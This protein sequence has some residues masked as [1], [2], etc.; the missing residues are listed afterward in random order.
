MGGTRGVFGREGE[1]ADPVF[2][3]GERGLVCERGGGGGCDVHGD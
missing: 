3:A 1:G 2:V